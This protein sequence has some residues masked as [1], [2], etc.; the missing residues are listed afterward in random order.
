[1]TFHGVR[2]STPF[3][4]LDRMEF[5]ANTCCVVVQVQDEKP[6]ILDMGTGLFGY[7]QSLE[8]CA[9]EASVLLTHLHWDHVAGLPFFSPVLCPGGVLDIYGPA[10]GG[11]SLDEAINTLIQ[12]PFF[13]V[14]MQAFAGDIRIHDF[15]DTDLV[16]GTA[17]VRAR[18]VPHT[19]ATSGYR[20][21]INGHVIVYIPDHQQPLDGSMNVAPSVLELCDGAD[22]LIHDGQYPPELFAERAHW[23]HSTPAYAVEIARQCGVGSLA[24]FSHD[25]LHND[26]QLRAIEQCAQDA[27]ARSGITNVFSAREGMTVDFT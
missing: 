26:E 14:T 7:A 11:M 3:A 24:L 23:G 21:E 17:K 1:M 6:I 13:P 12:P 25:P 9:L 15:W 4:T 18:S 19:S 22:L 5:G 20:L 2:G 27:A 10:D 8:D 16:L